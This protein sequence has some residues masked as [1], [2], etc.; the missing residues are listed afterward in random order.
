MTPTNKTTTKE[1]RIL[2]RLERLLPLMLFSITFNNIWGTRFITFYRRHDTV[3]NIP[4]VVSDMFS[5]HVD[6][7]SWKEVKEYKQYVHIK[8]PE[9]HY[10]YAKRCKVCGQIFSSNRISQD[11]HDNLWGN[12]NIEFVIGPLSNT[13]EISSV[14][15]LD[16]A[17][18]YAKA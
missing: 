6:D 18:Y 5:I 10:Y 3:W 11:Q 13:A 16:A 8:Q 2:K 14:C 9:K 17:A 1:K 12:P 4:G 7:F 15:E